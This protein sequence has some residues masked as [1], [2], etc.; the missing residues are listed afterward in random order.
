M[1]GIVGYA[2][3]KKASPIL[4]ESLKRL[5]YRGY[6]SAGFAIRDDGEIKVIKDKGRIKEII[7]EVKNKSF[8]GSL[9]IGHC[10]SADTMV[11]MAN[12]SVKK[13]SEIK[14]GDKV[15][16]FD[17]KKLKFQ[18]SVVKKKKHASPRY[19]YRIKTPLG[20]I[21]CTGQHRMIVCNQGSFESKRTK[22]LEKKDL[23]VFPSK[24]SLKGESQKLK[25]VF[26]KRYRS[27]KKGGHEKILAEI[28]QSDR[29]KKEI[30]IE[31]SLSSKAYLDHIVA[32][33]RNFKETQ[34]KSLCDFFDVEFDDSLFEP[35]DSHHGNFVEFPKN[36]SPK[37]MQLFGYFV[38]DGYTGK[39]T[40]RF[41][42]MDK[43]LL[44]HY[45]KLIQDLF[46]LKGRITS[47]NDT[48][49]Y[50]LEVNSKY[51]SK[52]LK[53]NI[54][55]NK[56]FLSDLGKLPQQEIGA[57][58]GGLFDAEGWVG[59]SSKQLGIATINKNLMRTIQCLLTRLGII[60]SLNKE[61]REP[62]SW[63]SSYAL[64]LSNKENISSFLKKVRFASDEKRSKAESVLD[65]LTGLNFSYKH[66]PFQEEFLYDEVVR[67]KNVT[68][69]QMK[70]LTGSGIPTKR[71]SE[72]ILEKFKKYNINCKEAEDFQRFYKKDI[73]FSEIKK[74]EK[75]KSDEECLYDLQV[76]P[77]NNFIANGMLSH[78]SRWATHG[79]PSKENAHPHW[80]CNKEIF[81][82]HNGIIENHEKIKKELKKRGHKFV[83]ETDTEVLPHLFEHLYRKTKSLKEAVREGLKYVDGAYAI[84]VISSK[85]PNKIV[86][87][88][89]GSPLL[90]GLG[91]GENFVASDA[92]AI[93]KHTKEVIYLDEGEMGVIT[94]SDFEIITLDN[95]KVK[96][97][98]H[99]LDWDVEEAQKQGYEHFMLKE[100]NQEP[101]SVKDA[102]RG[103]II[104]EKGLVKLGGLE[105]VERQLREIERIIIIACGT[106]YYAGLI[107][108]YMI[109]EYA[110]IPCEVEYASEFR[111]RKP[112][113]KE[114]TA[115]VALSQ[116]G[117]TADTLAAVREAN[118]KNA[119]TLGIV[120]VVGST[121]A[122][123][124]KA[125]IYNHAGPEIGVA[126]TKNFVSQL[127]IL[128]LLTVFLGRERDMS[129]VMGKRILG[130]LEKVP[131][132]LNKLL[133]KNAKIKELA[134]KYNDYSDF[135]YLGRKYNYPIA[136]E[137]ALKLKEISYL[138]AE[139]Y[140]AGEM[141]HGPIALID[142][143]FPSVVL[144]PS[145]SVYEK[146]ISN[147]EEIRA[148]K[149]PLLVIATEGNEE[150]K[151][152]VDDIIFIPKT[153]E[154]LTPLVSILPLHLFAYYV[155]FLNGCNI[156]KPK[157]LAKSVTVE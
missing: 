71:T 157:N 18:I 154:M 48:R 98:T 6:D 151:E 108:E 146:V 5:E 76:D 69:Q 127:S 46:G 1:C 99:L 32:N 4:I 73:C 57:F 34:L 8:N 36:T 147:V 135:L 133:E 19:L 26:F 125:G 117:E 80:D 82:A 16:S 115:V 102:I 11:Q 89:K 30:S 31:A 129:L 77:N 87:A 93:V 10:L 141:K 97:E 138:H 21:K 126:S 55:D 118:Q 92:A 60:S 90:V 107:G 78:N 104:K 44:I 122:R 81:V 12:G 106:S 121:I 101:E 50:L 35:V 64:N 111:Y 51:L 66:T 33:D 39:R 110:G 140:S 62:E 68:K 25:Q 37:L 114:N 149:G 103:R 120:N 132:H 150:I 128:V 152:L 83:S 130:E 72:R 113:I 9:G 91:E 40:L 13:I 56:N 86:F 95:Q 7:P 15:L 63:S 27:L 24:L 52:W 116:S 155:A 142:E 23:L 119:L 136:L 139:G 105:S 47:Q 61:S 28:K 74:I 43:K 65:K 134:Q 3:N 70:E 67:E 94:P 145:D 2:G 131:V 45:Q 58:V 17:N 109:E 85:E 49:A 137:G 29:S 123:E 100:I 84:C 156:D 14:E 41:K 96:K 148:R 42:D 38:G 54:V 124:T 143:N 79:E 153:L 112:I 20:S 53:K 144:C 22:D 59:T 75:V 88:R